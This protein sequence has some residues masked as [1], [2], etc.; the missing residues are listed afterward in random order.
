MALGESL[1]RAGGL[2]IVGSVLF[3]LLAIPVNVLDLM[4]NQAAFLTFIFGAMVIALVGF[5]FAVVGTGLAMGKGGASSIPDEELTPEQ[6]LRK[7]ELEMQEQKQQREGVEAAAQFFLGGSGSGGSGTSGGGGGSG[8]GGLLSSG[9]GTKNER[10]GFSLTD[11]VRQTKHKYSGAY[12]RSPKCPNCG[13]QATAGVGDDENVFQ[14]DK[15]GNVFETRARTRR[16]V[17]LDIED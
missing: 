2:L 9:S 1:Q 17:N 16:D 14:C 15:C 13:S 5:L 12:V 7:R 3:G 4:G 6:Q 8:G 10:D 11:S